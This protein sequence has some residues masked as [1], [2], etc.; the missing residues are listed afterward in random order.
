MGAA[1]SDFVAAIFSECQVAISTEDGAA[2]VHIA[3]AI[4]TGSRSSD[5]GRLKVQKFA[6][7]DY[8]GLVGCQAL[9]FKLA[10]RVQTQ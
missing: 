1:T 6:R 3:E 7:D 2:S 9:L 10:E 5:H 8:T 4:D